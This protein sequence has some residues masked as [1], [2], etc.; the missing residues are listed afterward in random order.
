MQTGG[1][2]ASLKK[3]ENPTVAELAASRKAGSD[4]SP[5]RDDLYS[6]ADLKYAQRVVGLGAFCIAGFA[7]RC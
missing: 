4:P 6:P 2:L 7:A 3:N 1:D 5:F